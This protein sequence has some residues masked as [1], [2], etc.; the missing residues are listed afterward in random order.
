MANNNYRTTE[1]YISGAI[2]GHMWM[3]DSMGGKPF[4]KS[5]RGTWGILSRFTEPASFRDALL[6]LLSE[7]G[8]DFQDAQF[9]AD[10]CLTIVRKRTIAPYKYEVHVRE[11]ELADLKDCA[12]LINA[13]A[14]TSDFFDE[15]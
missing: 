10:T 4:R 3:P 7:E 14:F 13:E 12:D 6:L 2:C 1:A 15:D 8:G 5:L 9:S 11:R